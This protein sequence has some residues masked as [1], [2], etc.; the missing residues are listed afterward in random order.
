MN[1]FFNTL[2]KNKL[3]F[4]FISIIINNKYILLIFILALFLQY[5]NISTKYLYLVV[6]LNLL[7]TSSFI[8]EGKVSNLNFSI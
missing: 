8:G 3:I 1:K 6:L 4:S 2:F 5:F 7:N